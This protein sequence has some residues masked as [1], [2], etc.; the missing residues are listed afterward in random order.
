MN[1]FSAGKCCRIRGWGGEFLL[2][3]FLKNL[4]PTVLRRK[5]Y[6]NP[7]KKLH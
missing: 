5:K 4:S 6:K 3:Y 1:F 2:W 7:P